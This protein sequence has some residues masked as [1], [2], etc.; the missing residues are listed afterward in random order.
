MSFRGYYSQNHGFETGTLGLVAVFFTVV[1]PLEKINALSAS[2][3][4]L[5]Y[6]IPYGT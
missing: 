4:I 2:R 3:K 6:V 1:L 5:Y